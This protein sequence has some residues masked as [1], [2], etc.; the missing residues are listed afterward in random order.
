[1]ANQKYLPCWVKDTALQTV[2]HCLPIGKNR[3]H[4]QHA[5]THCRNPCCRHTKP[6]E[7]CIHLF[8]ECK[9]AR[10]AMDHILNKWQMRTN[11]NI[12][13]ND[14]VTRLFG[15]R[16]ITTDEIRPE[17]EE[18]FHTIQATLNAVIWRARCRYVHKEIKQ[19]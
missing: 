11:E 7:N 17:L 12:C 14:N 1:M 10:E 8:T 5:I 13:R 15:D 2:L 3:I 16:K 6:E 19:P 9:P 4:G 18:P